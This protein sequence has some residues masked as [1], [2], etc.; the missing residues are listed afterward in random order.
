MGGLPL[1]VTGNTLVPCYSLKGRI[2][3]HY[4]WTFSV[5]ICSISTPASLV[6]R[7][8]GFLEGGGRRVE[9]VVEEGKRRSALRNY[10]EDSER[11]HSK[12]SCKQWQW[13]DEG[14][15]GNQENKRRATQKSECGDTHAM[16]VRTTGQQCKY[17]QHKL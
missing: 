4:S 15:G 14:K 12:P 17:K 13:Q 10:G 2:T 6:V 5:I 9:N 1:L 11:A 7:L 16:E 8:C 3:I